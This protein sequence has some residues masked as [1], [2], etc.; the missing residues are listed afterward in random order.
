MDS[1]SERVGG[2]ELYRVLLMLGIV[3]LHVLTTLKPIGRGLDNVL[4][5]CVVGFVFISGWFGIRFSV[6]K[7]L[8]LLSIGLYCGAVAAVF[9]CWLL[10]GFSVGGFVDIFWWNVRCFWFLWAY[11][12]LMCM[13]PMVEQLLSDRERVKAVVPFLV[14][15]FVWSYLVKFPVLGEYVP[16][17]QGFG[18]TG[19][20][21]LLAIYCVARIARLYDIANRIRGRY[22]ALIFA[23]GFAGSW[24]GFYHYNSPFALMTAF[25]GFVIFARM[26][27]ARPVARAAAL[28]SPSVFSVYL[29]HTTGVGFEVIKRL[30]DFSGGG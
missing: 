22:L 6:K 17:V 9:H 5:T 4:A 18:P 15:I 27:V 1:R 26:S 10:R 28:L 23:A 21:T 14:M 13:A 30:G 2:I 7:V 8:K 24:V 20:L 29:M 12:A 11:I 19:V 25:A 3:G 16:V